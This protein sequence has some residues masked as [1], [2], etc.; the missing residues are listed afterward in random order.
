MRN[1][2][3]PTIGLAVAIPLSSEVVWEGGRSPWVRKGNIDREVPTVGQNMLA[4]SLGNKGWVEEHTTNRERNSEVAT[5]K[6]SFFQ[7]RRNPIPTRV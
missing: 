6:G 1:Q 5:K 2:L 7:K 3:P 4:D